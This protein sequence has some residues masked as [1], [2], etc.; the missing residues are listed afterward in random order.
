MSAPTWAPVSPAHRFPPALPGLLHARTEGLALFLRSLV[1]V[2]V[3]RGDVARDAGSWTLARPVEE[4]V[5]EPTKG[6]QDLVRQQL[7]G[8]SRAER[9]ILEAASMVGREFLS[10]VIAHLV[11][12]DERQVEEDLRRLGRVRRLIAEVDEEPLPDGTLAT[13]YRFAHGLYASVLRED[14]LPLRRV[15]LHRQ[16]A[17]RLRHHWGAEAPR[18]ATEIAWHC[19]EGRDYEGAVTFRGYAGDNAARLFAYAEAETHYD[20]AFRLTQKLGA[21]SRVQAFIRLAGQR[22]AVRLGQAR[23][24][25][26]TAD[27]E[28]ML[29]AA[30]R[31]QAPTGEQAALAGLCDAHFFAR[32]VEKMADHA[33][34]LLDVAIRLGAESDVDEARAR[35]GQVLVCEGRLAEA[36]AMLDG[37]I[38]S[39]RRREPGVA[40]K[41]GLCYRGF[42]RYWQARFEASESDWA[43]ALA[44]ATGLGDGFYALAARMFVGLARANQ[45]RI[46]E[47]LDDFADAIAVA[48][49][50]DDRYWLPRLVANLG[51]VHRE[52]GALDQAREY[53]TEGLRLARERPVPWAPES[54]ALF[55]LCVDDLRVGQGGQASALLAELQ[56]KAAESTWFR[57]MDDLRLETVSAEYWAVRGDQHVALEHAA[58]LA[59]VAQDLGACSYS[60]TA[61]RLRA[62]AALDRADDVLGAA[63]RLEAALVE[64]RGTRAPLE[65]WKSAR[66]LAL[67]AS[68]AGGRPGRAN[69]VRGV[70]ASHPDDRRRDPG[71]CSPDG[72]PGHSRSP[73]GT[74]RLPQCS[75]F[76]SHS[77]GSSGRPWK[78]TSK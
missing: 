34:E 58:R 48:R 51:W 5:L 17:A 30:R 64:L 61:E 10:P 60:T 73:R 26:A 75:G 43:E 65:M 19:E 47:A 69:G 14:L 59:A 46:S 53:D 1:D 52:L 71:R 44:V 63:T 31:A 39:A 49:R 68:P 13:R 3:E 76:L 18:L 56:A 24:D 72:I 27:F 37:V 15:E 12:R 9:E 70:R 74:G 20:W 29:Q 35:M 7:E 2:L 36:V 11:G 33:R 57:W 50:N 45:G 55:N 25:D 66:V 32:R 16:V 40:L 23:F 21:E 67:V 4:L 6:L 62:G 41:I 42:A 77:S 22:G 8:L 38:A 78:R 54:D 28:S